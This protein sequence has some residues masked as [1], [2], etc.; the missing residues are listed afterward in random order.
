MKYILL[1][2]FL[3]T[4]VFLESS[5]LPLPLSLLILFTFN[6]L[7]PNESIFIFAIPTGLLLDG[8]LFR[9]FGSTSI[10]FILFLG[11]V[12]LYKQK[13]EIQTM[14]FTL[15]FGGLGSIVYF[16]FFGS[17]DFW[18]QLGISLLI[19]IGLYFLFTRLSLQKPSENLQ[20]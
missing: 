11:V 5:I 4:A 1:S 13:F 14:Q 17:S 6:C 10:F 19:E 16:W 9:T 18:I 15:I 2:L 12:L 8:L 7:Y 20:Y 3:F